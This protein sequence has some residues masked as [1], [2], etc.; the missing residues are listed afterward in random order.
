NT[1]FFTI[2]DQGSN[3]VRSYGGTASVAGDGLH[4]YSGECGSDSP[5]SWN[6]PAG[7][8][9][10]LIVDQYNHRIRSVKGGCTLTIAGSGP[11][12]QGIGGFAGDGQVAT[13]A[14]LNEPQGVALALDGSVYIADTQNNRIRTTSIA[15][16]ISNVRVEATPPTRTAIS[17]DFL[18]SNWL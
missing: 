16:S 4:R 11:S 12:G 3:V 7:L 2:T 1:E 10:G 17:L 13:S 14:L 9:G 5:L 15:P 18:A 8:S 6:T